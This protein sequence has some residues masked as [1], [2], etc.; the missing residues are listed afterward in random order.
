MKDP[1]RLKLDV[2]ADFKSKNIAFKERLKIECPILYWAKEYHRNSNGRKMDFRN[3]PYLVQ[4][5]K[6]FQLH[7]LFVMMKC[8]QVGISE[9]FIIGSF[10]EAAEMGLT[11]F[12]ILPKEKSKERFVSNRVDKTIR[13]VGKYAE[14]SKIAGG[15]SRVS[16][17][18]FGK[19]TLV[20]VNSNVPDEFF[21]I[22]VDSAYTDEKDLCNQSNLLMIPDRLTRSD[23]K[24]ER[25][26]SNPS[27]E[28]FGIDERF[29]E[30]T[31]G[32]WFNKCHHCGHRF[33]VD[34]FRDIVRQIGKNQYEA[35]D[36]EYKFKQNRNKN[37][38][39]YC[40]KCHKAIDRFSMGEYVEEFPGRDW[41]GRQVSQVINPMKNMGSVIDIWMQS[42]MNP[43]KTQRFYNSILGL[44]YT[45]EGAKITDKMLNRLW[46][47]YKYPVDKKDVKGVLFMGIDVNL[48]YNVI[49]RERIKD[50]YGCWV[51]RLVLAVSLPSTAM[52]EN[53]IREWNPRVIVVDA[54]PEIHFV[55]SLK[56]KFKHL[57]S[58]KFQHAQL[59]INISK[60]D[61]IISM[62]RTAAI[63]AVK[64]EIEGEMV[65]LPEEAD[66][67]V[68]SG[69]YYEQMK[70]S[71]RILKVN[72]ENPEKSYFSWEHSAPDHYLLAEVYCLQA[73]LIVPR[74]S[75]IDFYKNIV[76]G[77]HTEQE[78]KLKEAS[79]QTNMMPQELQELSNISPQEF[80]NKLNKMQ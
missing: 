17:K 39:A 25:E 36:P 54:N 59:K 21:E 61:R 46:R 16:L 44:P 57:Y 75:I 62:D 63:D 76:A 55:M 41:T 70:S 28:G 35:I 80:L 65:I 2:S 7:D 29:L 40:P 64:E 68:D 15:T 27:I 1:E 69:H 67:S 26:I 50:E 52:V 37:I 66:A 78:D 77:I 4:L 60:D 47:P 11:V 20:Y 38:N 5:Y 31:K 12:Y 71:T 23:Y 3:L 53:C 33:Y 24:Y 18:H 14:F 8:V 30:S 79:K 73:D 43:I 51:R 10:Y 72:E 45:S 9:L 13:R 34:F 49:I 19:G 42:H 74:D 22:P 56:T 32:Y 48:S 6:E 58:S